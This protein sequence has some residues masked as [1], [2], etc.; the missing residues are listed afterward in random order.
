MTVLHFV[1]TVTFIVWGHKIATARCNKE[2]VHLT[3]QRMRSY[4]AS[5]CQNGFRDPRVDRKHEG[6]FL[7]RC[8]SRKRA[9]PVI[10][11]PDGAR[12][13]HFSCRM[14]IVIVDFCFTAFLRQLYTTFPV[15]YLGCNCSLMD[16]LDLMNS[17]V[18]CFFNDMFSNTE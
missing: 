11:T 17:R 16:N 9:G 18:L 6:D 8:H 5:S 12:F 3:P 7:P 2:V 14:V 1:A 13:T 4:S 10:C 15:V